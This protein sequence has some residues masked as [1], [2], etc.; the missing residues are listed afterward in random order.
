MRRLTYLKILGGNCM[1][2]FTIL[3]VTLLAVL[4]IALVC[5][6]VGGIGFAAVFGDVIVFACIVWLIVKIFRRKKKK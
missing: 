4:A 3:L 1:I 5:T 6:I 2:L